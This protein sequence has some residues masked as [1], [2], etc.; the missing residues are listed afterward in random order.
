MP[1]PVVKK[2][3]SKLPSKKTPIKKKGVKKKSS[4][5]K[6]GPDIGHS[7]VKTTSKSEFFINAY[8]YPTES[9]GAWLSMPHNTKA[10]ADKNANNLRTHLISVVIE[11]G[12]LQ[13]SHK[14]VKNGRPSGNS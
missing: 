2:K 11:K 8:A 3:K 4:V 1:K 10:E 12:K 14:E 6:K 7:R 9:N 13:L 5:K